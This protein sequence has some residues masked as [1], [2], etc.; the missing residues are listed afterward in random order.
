M[1]NKYPIWLFVGSL[2]LI[3]AVIS[4]RFIGTH[5]D[6][7]TFVWPSFGV[8]GFNYNNFLENFLA[9][10]SVAVIF[11]LLLSSWLKRFARP[12]QIEIINRNTMN[13]SIETS[14]KE[15]GKDC[16]FSAELTIRNTGQVALLN[17]I[18]IHIHIPKHIQYSVVGA[19]NMTVMKESIVGYNYIR[20]QI[21]VP[22]YPTAPTEFIELK[23]SFP[24]NRLFDNS[25]HYS[26]VT[27]FGDYPRTKF[28]L[29]P[30]E[31]YL[32]IL[33]II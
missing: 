17:R 21:S 30:K 2:L 3:L 24:M 25:I 23:G 22:I 4:S 14:I 10:A 6:G 33:K 32:G 28:S 8:L 13:D 7:S 11:G 19:V 18:Y 5:F 9:D 26:I 15:N 27:E 12:K 16:E 29:S 20:G 1:I 31:P